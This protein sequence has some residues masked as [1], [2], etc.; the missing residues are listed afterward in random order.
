MVATYAPNKHWSFGAV[1]VYA[2]GTP[3]TAPAYVGVLNKNIMIEYNEHNSNRLKPYMRLDL[4]VNYKWKTRLLKENG[5]NLSL[6]NA[7]S[8]SNELF[9]YIESNHEGAF[10][11]SPVE[12]VLNILPSISYFCKF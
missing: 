4:S 6:Y 1:F 3:F 7:T 5:I 10:A 9:Y 2:S 11:Y 12:L 8:K